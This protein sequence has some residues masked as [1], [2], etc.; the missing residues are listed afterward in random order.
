MKKG[1]LAEGFSVDPGT[2]LIGRMNPFNGSS[3]QGGRKV[4][5][6]DFS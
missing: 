5:S 2:L 1:M 4:K 6:E 3:R